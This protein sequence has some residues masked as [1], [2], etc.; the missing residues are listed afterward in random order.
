M[1]GCMY[2][3]V[4]Y[5]YKRYKKDQTFRAQILDYELKRFMNQVVHDQNKNKG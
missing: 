2:G 3:F 1:I 4:M 5:K